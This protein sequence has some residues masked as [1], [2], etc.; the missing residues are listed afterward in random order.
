MKNLLRRAEKLA[1]ELKA[2]ILRQEGICPVC[3]KPILP[4][5]IFVVGDGD[6]EACECRHLTVIHL[7]EQDT[8][9]KALDP[10]TG[11]IISEKEL[12]ERYKKLAESEARDDEN[13]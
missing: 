10:K 8:E 6:V 12:Q 13:K 11:E 4:P 5:M 9:F 1:E 3:K 7:S 2:R